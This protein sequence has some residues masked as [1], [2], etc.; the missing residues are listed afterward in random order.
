MINGGPDDR[1]ADGEIHA[2]TERHQL[3]R[4]QALVMIHRYDSIILS[5]RGLP[6]ESVGWQWIGH[7]DAVVASTLRRWTDRLSLFIAEQAGFAGMRIQRRDT[8]PRLT[9]A[10]VLTESFVGK[11]DCPADPGTS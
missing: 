5:A 4:D 7:T 3:Q 8:D 9:N 10:E 1:Q 6:E 2:S 11:P